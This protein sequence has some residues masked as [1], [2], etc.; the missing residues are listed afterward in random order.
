MPAMM[1]ALVSAIATA[2]G[3]GAAAATRTPIS[4]GPSATSSVAAVKYYLRQSGTGSKVLHPVALPS[5]WYLTWKFDCGTKKGDF[6]L[7]A[8]RKSQ[9]TFTV[10]HQGPGLGGGGQLPYKKAGTYRFTIKTT[11]TWNLSASSGPPGAAN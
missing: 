8:N 7:T 1:L 3:P 9:S 6:V 4:R 10:A 5:R 11:C 2:G